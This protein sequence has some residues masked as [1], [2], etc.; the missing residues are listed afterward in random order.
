MRVNT[1]R[2]TWRRVAIPRMTVPIRLA[3][4]S[5]IPGISPSNGSNP[6]DHDVPGILIDVSST[7][8]R[9]SAIASRCSCPSSRGKTLTRESNSAF[10][11]ELT[12]IMDNHQMAWRSLYRNGHSMGNFASTQI[13]SR[14]PLHSNQPGHDDRYIE[15]IGVPTELCPSL[16]KNESL[17]RLFAPRARLRYNPRCSRANSWPLPL[18]NTKNA[19]A[20]W[21]N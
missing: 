20:N 9:I 8:A 11:T 4:T 18:L 19:S 15:F 10:R 5:P 14:Y 3:M 6:I 16:P 1:M 2:G 12:S 17:D 13:F 21:P 7:L